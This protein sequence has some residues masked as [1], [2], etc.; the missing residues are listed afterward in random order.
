MRMPVVGDYI[1]YKE[2]ISYYKVIS[3][4][5]DGV[6]LKE[7]QGELIFS[8]PIEGEWEFKDEP[9]ERMKQD[10]DYYVAITEP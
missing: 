4:S 10:F 6:S 5:V 3:I 1:K 9:L 8:F 7:N 2:W